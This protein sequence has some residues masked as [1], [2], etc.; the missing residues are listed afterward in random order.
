MAEGRQPNDNPKLHPLQSECSRSQAHVITRGTPGRA[1]GLVKA[2]VLAAAVL[3]PVASH[4][5]LLTGHGFAVALPL[6]TVQAVAI[7][8]VVAGIGGAAASQAE[9]RR[10][11]RFATLLSTALLLILVAGALQSPGQGLRM[12]SGATHAVLYSCLLASFAATLL[13]GRTD[14]ITGI[15]QRMNPYFQPGMRSY[16][17]HATWAWCGFF[18]AELATSAILLALAPREWWLLFINFLHLPLV[19]AMFA[20]EYIVRRNTFPGRQSTDLT[21]MLRALRPRR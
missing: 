15:A 7:G 9:R 20:A 13:P 17:R 11:R 12:A 16:T 4:A 1:S 3:S 18:A 8:I 19:G 5:A 14:M 6:A 2:S 10:R 21:T